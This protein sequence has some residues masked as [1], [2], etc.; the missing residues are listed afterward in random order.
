MAIPI[1]SENMLE[2]IESFF[3]LN[4]VG[5]EKKA[6]RPLHDNTYFSEGAIDSNSY[7]T[8]IAEKT[9]KSDA[10]LENDENGGP[11]IGVI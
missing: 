1:P 10:G 7:I 6:S 8:S 5:S 3:F 2:M 11:L 9:D 4:I